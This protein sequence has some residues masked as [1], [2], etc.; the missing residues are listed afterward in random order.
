MIG[1]SFTEYNGITRNHIARLNPDG[2]LDSS[3]VLEKGA[4]ATILAIALQ[5][6]GKILIGGIFSQYND[7]PRKHL[8]RLNPDGSLDVGFDSENGTNFGIDTIIL[9]PED[10]ILISGWFNQYNGIP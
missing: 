8:A 10:K 7:V 9:Q 4:D 2:S 6:D 3:F 5:P 1:G